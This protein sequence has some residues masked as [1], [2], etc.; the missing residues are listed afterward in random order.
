MAGTNLEACLLA[1]A[2]VAGIHCCL[3]SS[4]KEKEVK[5]L[6]KKKQLCHSSSFTTSRTSLRTLNPNGPLLSFIDIP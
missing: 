1:I 4:S 5:K 3:K 2:P 6:T